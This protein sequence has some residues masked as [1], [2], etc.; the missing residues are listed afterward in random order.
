M[1]LRSRL[2]AAVGSLALCYAAAGKPTI[3]PW[4]V[5]YGNVTTVADYVAMWTP[6]TMQLPA[7]SVLAAGSAYALKH[8]GSLGYATTTAGEGLY[9]DVME[10]YGFPALKQLGIPTLAMTYF[11]HNDGLKIVLANPAPFITALMAKVTAYDLA[12]VDLDYEPQAV[13]EAVAHLRGSSSGGADPFFSFIQSLAGALAAQGKTLTFDIGGGCQSSFGATQCAAYAAMPGLSSI[14]TEDTF[15]LGSLDDFKA[16]AADNAALGAAW[17]PGLE[18]GGMG[19]DLLKQVATYAG[20]T[21]GLTRL[22][23][24]AHNEWNVGP[25]PDWLYAGWSAFLSAAAARD[26]VAAAAAS[27][28]AGASAAALA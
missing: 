24:W 1:A 10:A 3:L 20:G 4:L 28:P 2:A 8:N 12:G 14:N 7:G 23:S 17:A 6:L 25:Q 5:P 16:A 15:G 27:A 9:G 13:T 11:T 21:A 22:A 19:A 18:P 26:A